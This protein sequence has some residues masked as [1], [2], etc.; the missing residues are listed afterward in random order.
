MQCVKP[1]DP[2]LCK[3]SYRADILEKGVASLVFMSVLGKARMARI[4]KRV[5]CSSVDLLWH[6][7]G[8]L[9]SFCFLMFNMRS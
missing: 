2:P 5:L 7:G 1:R 3:L 6:N 9:V 4:L 8:A